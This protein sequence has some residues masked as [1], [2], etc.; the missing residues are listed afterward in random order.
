M[1]LNEKLLSIQKEVGTITKDSQNPFFKSAYFDIN[2]LVETLKPI[3]NKLE[4]IILQPVEYRDGKN[5]L[6][7]VIVDV[8]TGEKIESSI[9]I[10]DNIEPQKMGSAITYLRRYSLQSFIFL[11]AED[12]DGS[13]ASPKNTGAK[14]NTPYPKTAEQVTRII[15]NPNVDVPFN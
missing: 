5:L 2:K 11:Q 10:P 14:P 6:S 9:A 1:S 4:V 8:K 15:Q 13:A 12:D 3:L 7:T